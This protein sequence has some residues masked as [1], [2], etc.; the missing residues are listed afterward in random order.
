MAKKKKA[1]DY[2]QIKG[3]FVKR[4]KKLEI[5]KEEKEKRTRPLYAFRVS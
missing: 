3:K 1:T 4:K 5:E 2:T